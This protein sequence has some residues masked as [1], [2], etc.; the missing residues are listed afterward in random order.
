MDWSG[1]KLREDGGITTLHGNQRDLKK[2]L[3][4]PE[5]KV[6]L[7]AGPGSS[8]VPTDGRENKTLLDLFSIKP[9]FGLSSFSLDQNF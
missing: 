7:A 8:M 1:F 4:D 9:V 6:R 3:S 2:V 5:Q